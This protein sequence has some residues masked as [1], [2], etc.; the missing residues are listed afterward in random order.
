MSN[1]VHEQET[2]SRHVGHG[3][4]LTTGSIPRHLLRFSGPMFLANILQAA[5]SAV[6]TIWVMRGLGQ[7]AMAAA[8]ESMSVF[9]LLMSMAFGLTMAAN[10]LAAQSYGAKDWEHVKRVVQNS[11]IL[12]A[13]VS[14]GCVLIGEHFA[15]PV[16]RLLGTEA[17]V[18]PTAV[19][20]LKLFLLGMPF[21]FGVFLFSALLRG[22]GDSITPLYFQ[23]AF[24]VLTAILDPVLMFGWLGAPRMGLNG[25]AVATVITQAGALISLLVYLRVKRHIIAPDWRHLRCDLSTMLLSIR[26]GLPGMVQQVLVSVGMLVILTLVNGYGKSATAAYGVAQRIDQLA[27]LPA[28]TVGMAASAL[29]GQNIG[30]GRFDRVH[31]VYKWGMILGCGITAISSLLVILVPQ[32]LLSAFI[33]N[34]PAVMAIAVSYLRVIGIGYMLFAVMFVSNGVINGAGHTFITT[35]FTLISF[36]VV[37]VPLA[38]YFSMRLHHPQGI[39]Y[40]MLISFGVGTLLSTAYYFSNRWKKPVGHRAEMMNAE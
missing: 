18:M 11:V 10:I 12:I 7:T 26:I 38:R 19:P 27:F 9:F 5:Y 8:T 14:V 23:A 20:Y 1:E 30:A 2:E 29:G 31:D 21:M 36:W 28:M 37:R 22:A 25:T 33:R 17:A 34:E 32:V 6:N 40:G 16:L 3:R 13:V 35:C 4:D 15:R 24:L 39:W